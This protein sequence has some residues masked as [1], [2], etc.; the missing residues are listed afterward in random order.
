MTDIAII[1]GGIAGVTAAAH[2]A[3]HGNV[4]LLEQEGV[5]FDVTSYREEPTGRI[6]EGVGI[7]PDVVV[8]TKRADFATTDPVLDTA[9]EILRS[10]Q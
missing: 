9:L 6:F 5:A 4:S 10:D 1:G 2:L 8:A 3:P 7:E